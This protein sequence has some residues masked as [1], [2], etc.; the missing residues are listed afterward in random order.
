MEMDVTLSTLL[1]EYRLMPTDATGERQHNRGATFAPGRGGR[2]VVY[3]RAAHA[4]S[5]DRVSAAGHGS[6]RLQRR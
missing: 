1:R 6:R 3:R 2:A 5:S 4:P